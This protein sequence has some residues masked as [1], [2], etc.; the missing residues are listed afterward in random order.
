METYI[1]RKMGA[2][3]NPEKHCP[4]TGK[5]IYPCAIS[6]ED[7]FGI[8][9]YRED[10]EAMRFRQMTPEEKAWTLSHPAA[11]SRNQARMRAWLENIRKENG[12]THH[13]G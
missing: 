10:G 4:Y 8:M 9:H 11:F 7:G 1:Q 12:Q 2:A 13:L 5:R 3:F 6:H